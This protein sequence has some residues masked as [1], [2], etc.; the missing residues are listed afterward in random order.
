MADT[1]SGAILRVTPSG[2]SSGCYFWLGL[3]R[4][5]ETDPRELIDLS[6]P[7]DIFSAAAGHGLREDEAIMLSNAELHPPRFVYLVP[8]P[9]RMS[10]VDQQ[11][12]ACCV[13][14][15][16]LWRPERAGIY[17]APELIDGPIAQDMLLQI[18]RRSLLTTEAREFYLL[19]G[20]RERN[21]LL[22]TAVWL[23][24]HLEEQAL[25]VCV[26]H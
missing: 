19:V 23:K 20:S 11:T 3:F 16:Q 13:S 21:D 8:A 1:N 9:Q 6:E 12:V 25:N 4:D 14:A 10:A 18:L 5:G 24:E 17:I 26:Y 2:R 22:K 15:V 7:E